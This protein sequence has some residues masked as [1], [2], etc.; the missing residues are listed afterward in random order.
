MSRNIKLLRCPGTPSVPNVLR[1]DIQ[2]SGWSPGGLEPRGN[3]IPGDLESRGGG[4]G[5]SGRS[6]QILWEIVANAPDHDGGPAG[7]AVSRCLLP[8]GSGRVG[9]QVGGPASM[10]VRED[11][12]LDG[13]QVRFAVDYGVPV[14][15]ED[16][17]REAPVI[18]EGEGAPNGVLAMGSPA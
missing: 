2:D 7:A 16:V 14:D 11:G 17:V 12:V 5:A 1:H 15:D 10:F 13:R 18:G 3:C 9:K 4:G 6:W 8:G